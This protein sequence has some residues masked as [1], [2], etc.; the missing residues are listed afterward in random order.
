MVNTVAQK[1][2]D[3]RIKLWPIASHLS[4]FHSEK[5]Y[6]SIAGIRLLKVSIVRKPILVRV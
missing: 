6:S 2:I 5:N 4:C 3:T 1:E